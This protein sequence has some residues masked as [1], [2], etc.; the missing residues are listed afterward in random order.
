MPSRPKS[1]STLVDLTQ[2]T[3]G[4]DALG[5]TDVLGREPWGKDERGLGG[6]F[7]KIE[8]PPPAR[9]DRHLPRKRRRKG[10]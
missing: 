8:K 9:S 6:D 3:L 2:K 4:A 1:A 10:D 5:F 7:G